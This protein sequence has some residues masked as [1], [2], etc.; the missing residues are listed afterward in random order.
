MEKA[1]SQAKFITAIITSRDALL[2]FTFCLHQSQI[3]LNCLCV[4]INM[5]PKSVPFK[6]AARKFKYRCHDL[7]KNE[8]HKLHT[9]FWKQSEDSQG[10]FLFGF[11]K[12]SPHKATRRQRTTDVPA[13]S[14]RQISV[15][16]CLPS[17][18]GH[19]QVCA[20]TFRDTLGV[21][22]K[23]TYT[24]IEKKKIDVYFTNR[25]GKNPRSHSHK[26]KYTDEDIEFIKGHISSFLS[27]KSH[28][29]RPKSS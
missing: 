26:T 7:V 8:V 1:L 27:D 23:R 2:L 20:K 4:N 24:V 3:Q 17:T 14:R 21:S 12:H 9:D 29:S 11:N 10:N 5:P 16:Y 18:N 28:Y 6:L 13:L 15:T 19:I 22:Q 25:R